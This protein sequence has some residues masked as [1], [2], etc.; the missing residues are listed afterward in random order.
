VFYLTDEAWSQVASN[1]TAFKAAL[2]IE[3]INISFAVGDDFYYFS[4]G[5]YSG[6]DCGEWLN[7]A[8]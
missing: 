7:H 8:M 3:P 6:G 2:L 4:S 5:V 1:K